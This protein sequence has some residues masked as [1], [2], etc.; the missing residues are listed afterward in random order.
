MKKFIHLA[1]KM[2]GLYIVSLTGLILGIAFDAA[3]PEVIGQ[4]VDL[5][6]IQ[7]LR[8]KAPLLLLL[9][10]LCH[11]LRGVAK[12]IEEYASDKLSQGMTHSVR[13]ILMDHI[14]RQNGV[15]FRENTPG[16]I[17]T[18]VRHD[19]EQLGFAFGFCLIFLLEI[20]VHTITMA[21]CLVLVSPLMAVPA[22]LF[23]PVIGYLAWKREVRTGKLYEH[24]SDETALMNQTASEALVGIRTVRAFNRHEHEKKRFSARNRHYYELNVNLEN[25]DMRYDAAMR[26]LS[27]VMYAVTILFG[28]VLVMN[29]RLTLGLLAS[30][31][32][33]VNNLVWPMMEIG[34]VMNEMASSSAAAKKIDALLS[35]HHEVLSGND[36]EV[37]SSFDLVYDSVSLKCGDE[38][39]I[40][41]ISF[42]LP[43][44][45]TLGI[46]GATGSGKSVLVN[47][48]SRFMDPTSGRITL[49]GKDISTLDVSMLRKQVSFV[50]QD[51]FLFSET[52]RENLKKGRLDEISDAEMV[53]CAIKADAHSFVTK[54]EKGYDTVIGER[55]VGLSG[56]QKQRLSIAR[57]L[58]KGSPILVLDDATS[59]LDS[60]TERSLQKVLGECTGMSRIIIGHR[61]SSVRNADEII[62]LE[63]GRIAERG[64]HDELM[65]LGGLYHDTFV[66]QYGREA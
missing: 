30:A 2:K 16:D 4:L 39:L 25:L 47:L 54:L 21:V 26:T 42:T 6:M 57:A 33:Y 11:A 35:S 20:T 29:G 41:N 46:M 18:R 14:S 28:S 12:Y 13:T 5:V 31:V 52:V 1:L 48:L 3:V 44:G 61:I 60:E 27:R 64:N 40:N 50:T 23:L 59:A 56:G 17:L 34:W 58:L 24:I 9:L 66:S 22:F 63:N 38:V 49:G 7:D 43:M 51:V 32:T 8:D 36:G 19:S 45:K 10:F 62:Y 53:E 15:F 37:P 65:A 55:G